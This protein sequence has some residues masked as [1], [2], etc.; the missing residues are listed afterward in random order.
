MKPSFA[1]V[2]AWLKRNWLWA[3]V[4]VA[5]LWLLPFL[6]ALW[7]E[8]LDKLIALA[9]RTFGLGSKLGAAIKK[10][11]DYFA[12]PVKGST[13]LWIVGAA[14]LFISPPVGLIVLVWHG[15]DYAKGPGRTNFSASATLPPAPAPTP[16]ETAPPIEEGFV[17]NLIR[18]FGL[19]RRP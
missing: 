14:L 10:A 5:L 6:I 15:L 19:G 18:T 4:I 3:I 17:S 9:E 1:T 8:V 11:R 13:A 7:V 12:S 16:P 2:F